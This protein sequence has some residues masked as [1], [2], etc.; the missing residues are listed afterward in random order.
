MGPKMPY[1]NPETKRAYHREYMRRRRA[2]VKPGNEPVL[3][4][5]QE[6]P[7]RLDRAR[8]YIVESRY[9]WPAYLVQ[10]G[11]WFSP[12]TGGLVGKVR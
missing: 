8:R 9:P 7:R 2:D 4:P 1:K 5:A 12:D 3:I 10:D 11:L 6:G